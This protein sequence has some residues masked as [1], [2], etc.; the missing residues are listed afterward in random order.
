MDSNVYCG[1]TI[2]VGEES[3][4]VELRPTVGVSNPIRYC[5]I[6]F[7]SSYQESS[8]E[9]EI[10]V[11]AAQFRDCGLELH[12]YNGPNSGG[13]YIV[14]FSHKCLKIL[15]ALFCTFCIKF[16]FLCCGIQK[17]IPTS[18]DKTLCSFKSESRMFFD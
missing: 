8:Y 3:R 10:S 1:K 5:E 6:K 18:S 14:S 12:I 15:N 4:V 7:E 13:S 2:P 16:C 17:K 11:Q 9:F